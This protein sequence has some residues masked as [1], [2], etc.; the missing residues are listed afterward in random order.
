MVCMSTPRGQRGWW[1]DQW[2]STEI[3]WERI[4]FPIEANPQADSAWVAEERLILGPVWFSQEYQCQF[5]A[6]DNQVFTT[7]SINAAFDSDLE[8]LFL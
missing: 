7:E 8:P 1:H 4:E 3:A 2:F 6:S 5:I